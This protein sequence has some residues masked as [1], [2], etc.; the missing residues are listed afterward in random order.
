MKEVADESLTRLFALTALVGCLMWAVGV[1]ESHADWSDCEIQR[2]NDFMAADALYTTT[3]D[4]W[5]RG[6]PTTCAQDCN[7]Q[8]AN[9]S[10]PAQKAQCMSNCTSSCNN[11]RLNAYIGAQDNLSGVASRSCPY[12][13]DYCAAARARR[14]QCN[15]MYYSHV[16]NPM[17]N[18]DG[19]IDEVW[20][21]HV[22]QEVEYCHLA[23]GIGLCE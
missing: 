10:N 16:Q 2:F 11:S 3:F 4:S 22:M 12:S 1:R 15:L 20:D 6:L 17:Y 7:Q 21:A 9:I 5:H 18:P 8:C 13:L 14:D 19:S 23:S